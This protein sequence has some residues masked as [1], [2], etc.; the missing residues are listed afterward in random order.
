MSEE[1]EKP[2]TSDID[3]CELKHVL[4]EAH[5]LM[6]DNQL[7]EVAD[8]MHEAIRERRGDPHSGV[9]ECPLK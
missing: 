7:L 3:F 1:K 6:S 8:D 9:S 5:P 4:E 2:T